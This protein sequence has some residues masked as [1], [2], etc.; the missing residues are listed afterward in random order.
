LLSTGKFCHVLVCLPRK[1]ELYLYQRALER[2]L[3][4]LGDLANGK[5]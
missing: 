1:C 2:R 3:G 4:V 5:G